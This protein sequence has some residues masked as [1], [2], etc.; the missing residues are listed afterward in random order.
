MPGWKRAKFSCR[1]KFDQ[2]SVQD[3][4]LFDQKEGIL[5]LILLLMQSCKKMGGSNCK[6]FEKLNIGILTSVRNFWDSNLG[7]LKYAEP[8]PLTLGFLWKKKCN[9]LA[10]TLC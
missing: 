5:I 10:V 9:G 7:I 2:H 1:Y 4:H 8:D 3:D 6:N